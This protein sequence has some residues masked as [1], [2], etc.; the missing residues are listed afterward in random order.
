MITAVIPKINDM[1]LDQFE[2]TGFVNDV[3]GFLLIG[4]GIFGTTGIDLL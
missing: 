1:Q 3:S 4:P 2:A